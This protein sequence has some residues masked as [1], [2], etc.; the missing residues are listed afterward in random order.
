MIVL[1]TNVLSEVLRASPNETVLGWLAGLDR[2]QV[3][4]TAITQ[5]E[6]LYGI[7]T[8]PSG[9]RRTALQA[10]VARL[11]AEVFH[12]RILPFDAG[13][14][15]AYPRIVTRRQSIGRPISQFDAIIAAVCCSRSAA[16]ATRNT[17]DF[18]HCG[19]AVVNPWQ[20][21]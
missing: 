15:L 3:F 7:E 11:F 12:E 1:D 16:V 20:P 4:T 10:A 5:A 6:I 18:E 9:K 14:A 19:L 13:A 8:L 2:E 17:R 21:E